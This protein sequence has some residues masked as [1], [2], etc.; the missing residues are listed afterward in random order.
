MRRRAFESA[1][2]SWP[3]K[4]SMI[5]PQFGRVLVSAN[6]RLEAVAM[7]L[8]GLSQRFERSKSQHP[9]WASERRD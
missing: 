1:F 9:A 2:L 8:S 4:R 3:V 7:A 5:P 6:G